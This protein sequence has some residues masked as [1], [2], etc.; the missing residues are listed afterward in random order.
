MSRNLT[1]L[2]LSASLLLMSSAAFAEPAEWTDPACSFA[3]KEMLAALHFENLKPTV[4]PK[5]TVATPGPAETKGT[6]CDVGSEK[7]GVQRGLTFGTEP[8]AA[9]GAPESPECSTTSLLGRMTTFCGAKTKNTAFMAMMFEDKVSE[10][11]KRRAT[12]LRAHFVRR[13]KE[14]TK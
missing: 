6:V 10:E 12:V 14:L 3:D 4:P 9:E 1:S 8:L 7:D 13:F 5:K 11:G 2:A